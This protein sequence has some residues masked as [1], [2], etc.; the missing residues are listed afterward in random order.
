MVEHLTPLSP[1]TATNDQDAAP[2]ARLQPIP[3]RAVAD[4]PLTPPRDGLL[5]AL[6]SLL[7]VLVVS[8][9][10]TTFLLQ[11][12]RIPS[13]SMEPT[14][15]VGDFL[16]L[17]KQFVLGSAE[18]LLPPA[19]IHQDDIIVFHDPVD[20]PS[21]QLVKR[22]IGLPG[23]RIHLRDGIVYRNG[24]ALKESFAVHQ[25]GA[26]D[27]YRDNF[28]DL[29]TM[30]MRV[31]PAWWIALRRLAPHGELTVPHDDYFVMGDNRSNSA[32][33]RYWG[34]VPRTAIVG[35][36]MLIYFSWRQP[37]DPG[38]SDLGPPAGPGGLPLYLARSPLSWARWERTFR[39]VR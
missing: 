24:E 28:P 7:S 13:S 3:Y 29:Q 20:N 30:D 23:D 12:V 19:A 31:D 14:L 6:Q 9:F 35:Q 16:L 11:P 1:P 27:L 18:G 36:P 38:L 34:F 22:V 37:P 10:V 4:R 25:A 33:S 39:V 32:D 5:P 8:L 21:V 26:A 2:D 15:L 17:D